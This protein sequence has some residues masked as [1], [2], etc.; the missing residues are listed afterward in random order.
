MTRRLLAILITCAACGSP[1]IDG[2]IEYQVGGG[3]SGTGDGTGLVVE[4]DGSATRIRREGNV[5]LV[6]DPVTLGR[7]HEAIYDAQPLAG[8]FGPCCDFF[9]DEI[10]VRIDGRVQSV[11]VTQDESDPPAELRVLIELLRELAQN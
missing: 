1:T 9:S 3:I 8:A 2:P 7:L 10:S 6:L 5:A 11:S 4:L